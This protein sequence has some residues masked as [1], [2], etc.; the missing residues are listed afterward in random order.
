MSHSPEL[1]RLAQQ[2]TANPS[3]HA[4]A[5]LAEGLRKVGELDAAL[6]IARAGT[7]ANADFLPGHLVLARI[8]VDVNDWDGAR[9]A[10]HAA[11]ALDPDHPMVIDALEALPKPVQLTLPPVAEP[12]ALPAPDHALFNPFDE[13]IVADDEIEAPMA[14][15]SLAMVYRGQGHLDQALEVYEF[16]VA[17]DPANHLLAGRRNS[18]R[19]ELAAGQ[20]RPFDAARSGGRSVREW[21]GAVAAAG[22]PTVAAMSSYDA[23]YHAPPPPAA[24]G[25][26]GD[27]V[28]FQAWLRELER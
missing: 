9:S 10:L 8:C 11:Q 2:L 24:P 20:P 12:D 6:S 15:E 22:A 1:D 5:P 28:A 4:F 27:M 17:R 23:F 19:A 7:A 26:E 18:V 14:T 16:L 21:L 3:S 13:A 25:G